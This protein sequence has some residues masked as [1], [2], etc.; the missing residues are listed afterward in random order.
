MRISILAALLL[1]STA[2]H[3]QA[4]PDT[5]KARVASIITE[6]N[7]I[8]ANSVTLEEFGKNTIRQGAE[9]LSLGGDSVYLLSPYLRSR[10]WKVRYWIADI[11]GYTKNKDAKKPLLKVYRDVFERKEIRKC[12]LASLYRLG[13]FEKDSS[14]YREQFGKK[15]KTA[16][17]ESG[18]FL[19]K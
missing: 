13:I 3:S 18:G 1:F 5:T 12:A 6:L 17:S 15:E 9:V 16:N 7:I 11:L 19:I 14:I 4:A 8:S 2:S 10:D